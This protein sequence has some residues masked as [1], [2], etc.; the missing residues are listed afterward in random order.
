MATQQITAPAAVPQ[1]TAHSVERERTGWTSWLTTTDHKRIGIMYLV[2]TF[3]F[4]MLG[5]TEA[6]L[7]RLQLSQANNTLL[8]PETY[9]QLI[10]MHG[11]TM[12]FLF[13]VPVMAGFGNYFLPLMIGARDMAFPKLNALSFWLLAAG[14]IV[15]YGSIF[16]APPECGWTC[17]TPL[18]ESQFLPSGGVDA[19]IFLIHLT[20]LSSLIGAINFVA[21]IHNMRAR[22][23]SWGR[24]PLFVW[25]ILIYSYLLILALPVVA[26]AVT[27]LL[28]DR[29]FGT[30]FFDNTGGGDPL[31]WQHLFWF[32]GHPEVY[33]MVLP[34]FGM[35]SEILPVFAGKPIFGYK[36]I[37]ASTVA[38]AFLGLLVWAHHMF[39]TP[40]PTVVL[41]FFMLSSFTI[42]VP[43]GIK[44][45]NWLATLW[46][47]QI[48]MKTPLY[49]AAALP[50]PVTIGGIS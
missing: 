38:I 6:L 13:V 28:T 46:R 15:F 23:M 44:I 26:A 43:T 33:I 14:G 8:D 7:I 1:V 9:N 11:T 10:T 25:S 24:M 31:L 19:W 21:T 49:F 27:M 18:S 36:A 47:G 17:Y 4:F 30:A 22:G 41:A 32:F 35:I 3:V 48:V 5:G 45:F 39:A 12:I 16:F 42:A 2:L 29:H 34:A 50:A 40:T 37:A 20:G